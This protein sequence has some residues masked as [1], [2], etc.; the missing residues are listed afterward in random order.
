MQKEKLGAPTNGHNQ[1][2]VAAAE[3][4]GVL[5]DHEES[6]ASYCFSPSIAHDSG[7]F[8]LQRARF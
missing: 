2:P 4:Q 7:K 5:N 8:Y 1:D 6:N 3:V